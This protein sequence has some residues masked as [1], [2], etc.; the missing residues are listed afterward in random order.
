[1]PRVRF[2]DL[3]HTA[4]SLLVSLGTPLPLVQA[5]LGHSQVSITADTYSHMLPGMVETAMA[6]LE[7]LLTR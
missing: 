7:R 3:R 6:D 5:I 2:H 4:A 1:L